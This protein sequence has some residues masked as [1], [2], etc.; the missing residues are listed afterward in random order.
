MT[1]ILKRRFLFT[2]LL[3]IGGVSLP[4]VFVDGL[5]ASIAAYT[6]SAITGIFLLTI[7]TASL[8]F[9]T[10]ADWFLRVTLSP[11]FISVPYTP[12]TE[13]EGNEFVFYGWSIVRDFV[14]MFFIL[15]LIIIGLST[16]LQVE[17]YR[18]QKTLPRLI[19]VALLVNFTPVVLGV[20]IDATN[21][22]M[23][24]FVTSLASES[25]FVIVMRG[26]FDV[27]AA[28]LADTPWTSF[29][30]AIITPVAMAVIFTLF[31]ALT[32]IVYGLYSIIFAMR[33][34][35]IWLLVIIS[36]FGFF[37]YILPA[38]QPFFRKWWRWFIGWCL[39][40][41]AGAFFLYLGE[42]MFQY[43]DR[44]AMMPT[45][46][47]HQG[48]EIGM[49]IQVF[50]MLIP[51]LFILFGFFVAISF[52]SLG[53]KGIIAAFEKASGAARKTSSQLPGSGFREK[54]QSAGAAVK[55]AFT[56][57]T[58][59]APVTGTATSHSEKPSFRRSSR[60]G[61][62][63]R[64]Q[65][66]ADIPSTSTGGMRSPISEVSSYAQDGTESAT[67]S[68]A[69]EFEA[70]TMNSPDHPSSSKDSKIGKSAEHY[71][72]R[73]SSSKDSKI[74]KSAEHY[75]D[76]QS[77][78]KDSGIGKGAEHYFDRQSSSKDSG[79]G[80]SA[81]QPPDR[82][83]S[84]K[85]PEFGKSSEQYPDRP[86][87]NRNTTSEAKEKHSPSRPS[88]TPPSES[89]QRTEESSGEKSS[90]KFS[91][92]GTASRSK[93]SFQKKCSTCGA[94]VDENTIIC[95]YC[96]KNTSSEE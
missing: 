49:F 13:G 51:L 94:S 36:P 85:S 39:I 92:S 31:N 6:A 41:I 55:S 34:V 18:W 73:Q 88:Y 80:K 3:V 61:L 33:Y 43:I 46:T 44:Q 20:F 66:S 77:S 78:S 53:S 11:E 48:M 1:K 95:P 35:A 96:K 8:V 4:L 7:S 79:I 24:Y 25:F 83:S 62:T 17:T 65:G 45:A 19:A 69:A 93:K 29:T 15:I 81:E 74:G 9:S 22:M 27:M 2:I 90:A 30:G 10:F 26:L 14:N 64:R 12:G 70:G 89:H 21:I 84:P 76:R 63:H 40:G 28:N 5:A 42:I 54:T 72:D 16:S 86:S 68:I 67:E 75:F 56:T 37:C 58:S 23:N 59:T 47:D 82:Q 38:T 91:S 32:G 60:E 52:S 71:F 50:P 57:G 87:F